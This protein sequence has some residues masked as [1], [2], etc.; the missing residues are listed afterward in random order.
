VPSRA[1]RPRGPW[2]ARQRRKARRRDHPRA[3][4]RA[5]RHRRDPAHARVLLPLLGFFILADEIDAVGVDGYGLADALVFMALSLPRYA[6]QVFPIATLIGALIG[7]GALASRSELVAM[8]AAGFSVA[9]IIRAGLL[10]GVL[11]AALAVVVGEVI[12]PVA[13]QRGS[14]AAPPSALGRCHP[15]D[16][17]WLLGHRRSRLCQHPRDRLADASA[18][19]LHLSGGRG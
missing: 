16:R 15:A 11:L 10:G 9:R 7:L 19:H 8:R 1:R 17:L 14:G 12:A 6:Y 18:R 2:R 13:E 5:C 4:S 3:L